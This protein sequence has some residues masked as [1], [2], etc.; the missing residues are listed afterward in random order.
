MAF[1]PLTAL[2]DPLVLRAQAFAERAHDGMVR[3]GDGRPYIDHPATVARLLAANGYCA[4][5][6]AAGW[7]HDT[8]E[9]T[10]TTLQ[11]IAAKFGDRVARLVGAVTEDKTLTPYEVRKQH[12][13][14]QVRAAG[15]QV[16]AIY[17][18]DKLANLRDLYAAYQQEGESIASRFNAPLDVKLARHASELT[19][20]QEVLGSETELVAQ[21]EQAMQ[22]LQ[23][24][25]SAS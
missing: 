21:L 15:P 8:V 1:D 18:A 3:K 5:M 19:M 11:E 6:V 17:A 7:L 23:A 4:E 12:H 10:P 16:A 13:L 25:R 20:L 9:D 14:D 24:A 22:D 2:R